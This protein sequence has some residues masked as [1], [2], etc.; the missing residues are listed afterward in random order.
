MFIFTFLGAPI[1]KL[2]LLGITIF[3][4][5]FLAI[6]LAKSA[7]F[8]VLLPPTLYTTFYP[9]LSIQNKIFDTSII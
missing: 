8:K 4:F 2:S 7:I 3:D 9:E 5:V 1:S 6:T